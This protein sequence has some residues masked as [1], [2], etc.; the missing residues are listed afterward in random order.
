MGVLT[1]RMCKL[2]GVARPPIDIQ[3]MQL[4][5]SS[6]DQRRGGPLSVRV[7][8]R[9]C[10]TITQTWYKVSRLHDTQVQALFY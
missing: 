3:L 2:D 4:K 5:Y 9:L 6:G 10:D 1:H 7:N 8:W